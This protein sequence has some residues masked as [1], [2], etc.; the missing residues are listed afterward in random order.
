MHSCLFGVFIPCGR[1]VGLSQVCKCS[2]QTAPFIFRIH[3]DTWSKP[4]AAYEQG[5]PGDPNRG[6]FDWASCRMGWQFAV[7]RTFP[8]CTVNISMLS[9]VQHRAAET[10]CPNCPN[11]FPPCLRHLPSLQEK[12]STS[13]WL[14]SEG[15]ATRMSPQDRERSPSVLSR[16]CCTKAEC[17]CT[18][19]LEVIKT[20]GM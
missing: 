13:R 12:K 15:K 16:C 1:G 5:Q 20:E 10:L 14:A 8:S 3:L 6:R 2:I 18:R 11:M 19:R 9:G 4:P 17:C 7:H